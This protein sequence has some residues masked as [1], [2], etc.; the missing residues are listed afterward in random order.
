MNTP[1]IIPR[2]THGQTNKQTDTRTNN[3]LIFRYKLS[4][5][6]STVTK[7]AKPI[8][9]IWT[10]KHKQRPGGTLVK[11]IAR[12]CAHGGMQQWGTTGKHNH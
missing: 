2:V 8:Q 10:F 11:H 4:Y 9:A 1:N 7:T 12:L 5:H 6:C 3:Y